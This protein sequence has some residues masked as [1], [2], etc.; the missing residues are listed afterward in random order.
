[1]QAILFIG[2]FQAIFLVILILQKKHKALHHKILA[3]WLIYLG[4]FT[5]TY[6][7]AGD[8]I[9]DRFPLVTN[10]FFSLFLLHGP[11][12]YFYTS[13]LVKG[14][15]SVFRPVQ[16]WHFAPV[17][18]FNLYLSLAYQNPEAA[19]NLRLDH[20]NATVHMPWPYVIFLLMIAISGP[21]YFIWTI[22]MLRKHDVNI[23]NRYS[24]TENVNL[25]WLRNLV[26]AFGTAWTL[27]MAFA[28][29]H[30]AVFLFTPDFCTNGLF[31]SLAGFIISTGYFGLKQSVIINQDDD[32]GQTAKP[33]YA[34]SSLS[35]EQ[36]R[37]YYEQLEEFMK[38]EKPFLDGSLTIQGLSE[39]IQAPAHTLSQVINEQY[40][41]NFFDFINSYRVEEVKRK[42]NDPEF[43]NY[44]LLGIA[45]DSGFNSKT[46]FNRVFKKQTSLT[47]GEFKKTTINKS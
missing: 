12:L 46:A 11:F 32:L 26:I 8:R 1:M 21:V 13:S 17:A 22:K 40:G 42:I 27:L 10:S 14:K 20:V 38:K 36:G 25:G 41:Q 44:S 6:A 34:G 35:A 29:V 28:I 19:Q 24:F 37:S 30:H 39:L 31:L 16:L 33:R 9:F 15:W 47:P 7:F 45:L 3:G 5:G 23:L 2:A 43:K 4:L 18:I